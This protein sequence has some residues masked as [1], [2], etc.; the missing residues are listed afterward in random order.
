MLTTKYI[1]ENVEL[2][3]DNIRKKDQ[4]DKL[5]LVDSL[6][7]SYDAWKAQKKELDDLRHQRNKL[8][9]E[10]NVAKKKGEDISALIV[11]AKELPKQIKELETQ[12]AQKD[13]HIKECLL[14]IPNIMH[15]DVPK[16]K[17]DSENVVR[18]TH[19]EAKQVAN[20]KNHARLAESLNVADFETSGDVA[21]KGFYYLKG[22]LARLNQA[23]IRFALDFMID[24]GYTYVEPPLMVRRKIIDGVMTFA[25]IDEMIF[26]IQDEDLYL[27]GTSEHSLIGLYINE[28]IPKEKLPLRLASYSMCFRKEVGSHGID[29]KGLWRTHQ[30][31][32]VEQVIICTPEQ[33]WELF[34]E[35]LQNSEE[36]LQKLGLPYQV[37]EM[38]TGDLGDMKARQF[39]VEAYLPRKQ[40]YGEVGSCSNL[41]GA[42]ATR[43]N[44]KYIDRQ[45]NRDTCH[46]L[47]NTAAATSRLLVAIL[48]NYQNEDGSV[49]IPE[50]LRPYM[51]GKEKISLE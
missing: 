35:L 6:L 10:I 19:G 21:G 22:D 7:S 28:T 44:I 18:K 40:G 32:K 47:N 49:T 12:I 31:N 1:R 26:K 33:S 24:K 41:T 20:P 4:L 37:L 17:D 15:K 48:E 46:T 29:E 34:D 45:N 11:K 42:Q 27:I 39:D 36:I 3:K 13:K 23:L 16:G 50:I 38:C 9:E 43:L 30:F 14:A 51:G 25:E 5:E 8:S 2:V